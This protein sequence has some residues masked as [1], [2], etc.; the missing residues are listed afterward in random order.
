MKPGYCYLCTA[1][2]WWPQPGDAWETEVY[3]PT[4]GETEVGRLFIDGSRCVVFRCPDGKYRAQTA[5]MVGG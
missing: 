4:G 1:P 3:A 5:V 2:H